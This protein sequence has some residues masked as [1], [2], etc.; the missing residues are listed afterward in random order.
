MQTNTPSGRVNFLVVGAQKCATSSLNAYLAG[1]PEIA[2]GTKKELH[3]FDRDEYFTE[4]R[5]DYSKYEARFNVQA[6]TRIKGECTPGYLF[7]PVCAE[8]IHCYNPDMKLIAVLRNPIQRAVSQYRMSVKSEV[9]NRSFSEAIRLES[10]RKTQHPF[11]HW[12]KF[13]YK[14][15]GQYVPQIMRYFTLFPKT[16]FHFIKY[17]KF[18]ESPMDSL[19]GLFDFLGV[20]KY[21]ELTK[22]YHRNA[23]EATTSIQQEDIRYLLNYFKEDI[24]QLQDL[25]QWDCSDWLDI[26]SIGEAFLQKEKSIHIHG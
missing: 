17:E 8:R 18:I 5:P 25:L 4:T 6:S 16:N 14:E 26:D 23:S 22:E 12:K 9:E 1:H 10:S 2:T 7:N 11:Y 21:E 19:N 13:A 20:E 15:R 24:E 3:F